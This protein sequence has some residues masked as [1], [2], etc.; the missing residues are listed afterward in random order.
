MVCAALP[1]NVPERNE[2][3]EDGGEEGLNNT[4]SKHLFDGDGGTS[5]GGSWGG[6]GGDGSK[7]INEVALDFTKEESKE[8]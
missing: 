6:N 7:T 2:G 5:L 1:S 3:V 4:L 8:I